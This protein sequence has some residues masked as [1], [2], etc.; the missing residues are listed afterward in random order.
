[1]EDVCCLQQGD[2]TH[3]QPP[4]MVRNT[5]AALGEDVP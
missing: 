4:D 3:Y 1:V 5:I 2:Y